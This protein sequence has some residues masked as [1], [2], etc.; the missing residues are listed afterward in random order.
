VIDIPDAVIEAAAEAEH[1]T[2]RLY[3]EPTWAE[4]VQ[5][6]ADSYRVHVRKILAAA[7]PLIAAQVLREA[8]N[9]LDAQTLHC[10]AHGSVMCDE[11]PT[12]ADLLRRRADELEADA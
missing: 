5:V 7:Y 4:L 10:A 1:A 12:G 8:A 3:D 9:A 11:C 6:D 2:D